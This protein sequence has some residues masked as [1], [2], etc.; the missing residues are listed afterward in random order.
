MATTWG[1]IALR[2]IVMNM[3]TWAA[4]ILRPS[5]SNY[6][7]Q[8]RTKLRLEGSLVSH[9]PTTSS[10]GNPGIAVTTAEPEV[11][12]ASTLPMIDQTK[13]VETSN[14][15]LST[16]FSGEWPF[17]TNNQSGR[18]GENTR[19]S[20]PIFQFWPG[21]VTNLA[22]DGLSSATSI[23]VASIAST[24]A[25]SPGRQG[26]RYLKP[27]KPSTG[28]IATAPQISVGKASPLVFRPGEFEK[29]STT[30][31][32]PLSSRAPICTPTVC[33]DAVNPFTTKEPRQA[34][35]AAVRAS[36]LKA[37]LVS[38]D[39]STDVICP[40]AEEPIRPKSSSLLE[41]PASRFEAQAG[42]R[43]R[44][45]SISV[46]PIEF[47]QAIESVHVDYQSQDNEYPMSSNENGRTDEPLPDVYRY[48][49]YRLPDQD[50]RWETA[51]WSRKMIPSL[52]YLEQFAKGKDHGSKDIENEYGV[53]TPQPLESHRFRDVHCGMPEPSV[54]R[55]LEKQ[56]FKVL[57]G[58]ETLQLKAVRM[59]IDS[60]SG[61]SLLDMVM[62]ALCYV[63]LHVW[64]WTILAPI[65]AELNQFLMR[66]DDE[67]LQ[68]VDI[69][70]EEAISLL[71]PELERVQIV[72]DRSGDGLRMLLRKCF[73]ILDGV[74]CLEILK[75]IDIGMERAVT[76]FRLELEMTRDLSEAELRDLLEKCLA[77]LNGKSIFEVLGIEQKKDPTIVNA[78]ELAVMQKQALSIMLNSWT[79]ESFEGGYCE[80]TFSNNKDGL[81][82]DAMPG[83]DPWSNDEDWETIDDDSEGRDE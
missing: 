60:A 75:F 11:A 14:V 68:L 12:L 20:K 65:L 81:G 67:A 78:E 22:D 73:A 64:R 23:G 28:H 79:G 50:T 7:S 72:R 53:D 26:R 33:G 80:A 66:F 3:H 35:D 24:L 38:D 47:P 82:A 62:R 30:P 8:C 83:T 27:R 21:F 40:R 13:H 55:R 34:P 74:S 69:R 44:S 61:T 36:M 18:N 54:S 76:L 15:P 2:E 1:L 4:R 46:T 42:R 70:S 6:I 16:P 41:P 39:R 63:R 25:D 29:P 45:S 19:S 17:P 77:I 71:R 10:S 56:A 57:D 9:A 32:A 37:I 48:H 58:R 52:R 31:Y 51:P 5:V 49:E 59:R 43:P